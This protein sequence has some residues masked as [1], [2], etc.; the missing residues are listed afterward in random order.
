M[1]ALTQTETTTPAAGLTV[2]AAQLASESDRTPTPPV[3]QILSQINPLTGLR[4]E[5][6]AQLE[7]RPVIVKIQNA[8]RDDRP[9][10]GLSGADIVFEYAI[11]FGDSRFAAIFYGQFP[12]KVGPIRSARHVDIHLV[13]AYK[14]ILV[15]GGAYQE[16]FDLLLESDFGNRLVREGP[17]TAP[18]LFRYDPEGRNYLL[19]DLTLL[20]PILEKYSID[21]QPQYL[22]GMR[23]SEVLPSGGED[24][25]QLGI[26]FS[27]AS[28]NG[29]VFD[30]SSGLYKRFSDAKN[31]LGDNDP[32]YLP[33][34]DRNSGEQITA[35]NVVV[36]QAVYY[37]LIK[38]ATSE[39]YDIQLIG[40]GTAYAARDGKLFPVIWE[41]KDESSV[42]SLFDK[43]GNLFPLRPGN[44]WFEI[45]SANSRVEELEGVRLFK[46]WLP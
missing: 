21:N 42:V 43:Q 16:L 23:F 17:N 8:P 1:P 7:R 15:F 18:A 20:N 27:G 6:S 28:Y 2:P 32:Q 24:V 19:A 34:L 12:D 26:R 39:V 30:S 35:A 5:D 46:N 25:A 4:V 29:W 36:L 31:D 38:T 14:S 22:E 11:E 40:S 33:L 44:T 45:L 3:R 9:P 13:R 41:R 10:F 37:P